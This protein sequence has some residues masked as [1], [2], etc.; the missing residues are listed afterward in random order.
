MFFD[1][2]FL[3]ADSGFK[4]KVSVLGESFERNPEIFYKAKIRL[5]EHVVN[6]G[7]LETKRDYYKTLHSAN[8]SVSTADHEFFGVAM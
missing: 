8:V 2:L 3:L 7:H 5:T 4:F 1:V 6:W